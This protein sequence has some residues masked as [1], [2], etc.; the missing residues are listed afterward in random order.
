[1]TNRANLRPRIA[2]GSFML[3]SNAHSPVATRE[4]FAQ[5]VLLPPEDLL[6]DLDLPHPSAPG[7]LVGFQRAMLQ[8][9]ASP[10]T[11]GR[12]ADAAGWTPVPLLAAAVGASGP[13]DQRWFDAI[14]ASITNSLGSAL[15]DGALDG[16]F[17]ALHGAA[18]ATGEADPDGRL[19]AAVRAVVG[20]D[21]PIVATF[22]LHGNV[23]AAM[24][25]A[26]DYFAAYL[27]NPHVDTR[28]RGAECAR[29]LERM[30]ATGARTHRAF[31]KLPFIPP[32]VTQNTKSGPYG[33]LIAFGQ[34]QLDGDVQ[35]VSV[36]SGFTLG[37]TPKAGMSV[38]VTACSASAARDTAHRVATRA[39]DERARYVPRLTGLDEA[40]AMALAVGRDS[41]AAPLLFADVADNAGGGGRANTVWVLKAFHDAGVVGCT[42]A[43]FYDPPLAAQAHA[44]GEGAA[45]D[46]QFNTAE[47]HPLSGRFAARAT[48]RR[49]HDGRFI[50]RRGIAAGQAINLGP[51]ARL[52]LGGIDVIVV[53]VRDQAKDPVFLEDLGVDI[54]RRRSLI[55]KSRG[56]FRAAFDEFFPDDRIIEVD[57]P[58]LT[59][60]V[61]ANVPWRDLPRPLY[62][63]DPD[64]GWRVGEPELF[65][66]RAI[67]GD[68]A[69]T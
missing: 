57:V 5:H 44:L 45:F 33:E 28:E 8:L 64:W 11:Y 50:G 63:L 65:A 59:T 34:A 66:P 4:E 51:C 21:V 42:L 13:I 47:T 18:I 30:I 55:I 16:V 10:G 49:L 7:S 25:A 40:T 53:S 15:R 3:E 38:V 17:L 41:A 2:L 43:L 12:S 58:G 24:V 14:V 67:R 54:A 19:L 23:S 36:L 68:G 6:D 9:V 27:T 31:V 48:V 26:V 61:L 29:A 37:D 56:H 46:A 60:P 52:D 69:G 32:S 35:N 39:W 62:P 1:M 22:D 20:A